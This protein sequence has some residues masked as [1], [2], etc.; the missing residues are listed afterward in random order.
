MEQNVSSHAVNEGERRTPLFRSHVLICGGTGCTSGGSSKVVASFQQELARRK[1]DREVLVVP[2]GCHGMCEM[3]P[4]VV[5]YPEGIFYCRITANDVPEIVEEHIYKGRPVQ[6]FMYEEPEETPIIPHYKDIPFY[7][8]QHRIALANC[9][10]I[11]PENIDEYIARGGY[12][13]L[14]KAI[15]SMTPVQ[16]IEEVKASGLRGRGGGGFPTGLKW[17]FCAA[18]R[19]EKK[20]VI[21]NADEGDPGAFMDRSILEGDPHCVI[22]GMMLGAF[23]MGADEGYVYCRAEYPLAIERL[24]HAIAAAEEYG[25]LGDNIMNSSFSFHLHIKEGVGAF[26]CGEETALMASIEGRRGM[27]RPR[28]PFPANSGLWGR[29]TNINNVETWANIPRILSNGGE[30]YASMGTEKS[31]GTKVFALTGKVKHT[32]LVE[33]PMGITLREIVFEIGGGIPNDKKFKAVQIGG[34]SGGCLTEEHLD[35]PVSYE[36]LTALGAIMGSGGLVVMDEDNC[37]VEVAKFFLA[38]VQKESCGKCP[39]CRIGTKRMLEILERITEGNGVMEDIDTLL[40]L[41]YQVKEGSLCGLG[42]TAPNPVLTTLKYFRGEYEAHIRDKKCPAKVCPSL[43]RYTIDPAA[44]IGC[45]KCARNCPVSCIAGEVKKPHVIDDE[46]CVRCGQ[47]KT[48][49]PV[50]AIS[51]E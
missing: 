23:A 3:G 8:K 42:Q 47:C 16:V 37:M 1:L 32:G 22:E 38:F 27:P 29:P 17:S 30:W 39:F 4:I 50:G 13:A 36:S 31:K 9:G 24:K 49:C 25:L 28:P 7:G 18:A 12:E 33:I 5:V 48:A 45:T 44:C 21:C 6:R 41:A 43:I 20:Y 19:G 11:N 10:Y 2:T 46:K 15:A 40:H 51:V 34:P 26:V 14:G 35:A